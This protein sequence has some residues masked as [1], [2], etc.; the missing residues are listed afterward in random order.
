MRNAMG[1][2][3][4]IWSEVAQVSLNPVEAAGPAVP[5]LEDCAA[6]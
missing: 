3:S 1:G 2:I 5:E 6:G 4:V